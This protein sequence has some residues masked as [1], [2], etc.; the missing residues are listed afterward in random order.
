MSNWNVEFL[1]TVLVDVSNVAHG[2]SQGRAPRLRNVEI[3]LA[4]LKEAR[5][6][7]RAWA[8]GNLRYEIDRGVELNDMIELGEILEVQGEPADARLLEEANE[9]LRSGIPVYLLSR[10]R[11]L[12][13]R[14]ARGIPR[15][16]FMFEREDAVQFRPQ[17]EELLSAK[18]YTEA[19]PDLMPLPVGIRCLHPRLKY[20]G[21][22]NTPRWI[23]LRCSEV[24]TIRSPAGSTPRGGGPSA[25]STS[26]VRDVSSS[27]SGLD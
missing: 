2:F 4:R 10:D 16:E 13:H 6:P 11:F 8:D 5:Q 14:E 22:G 15:I 23:C 12:D 7:Y 18:R 19:Y 9:L 26:G 3:V 1:P 25:A 20:A 24:T 17:L 21:T 27:R